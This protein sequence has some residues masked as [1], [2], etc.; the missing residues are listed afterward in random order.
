MRPGAAPAE[1]PG[2]RRGR[3]RFRLERARLKLAQ[4]PLDPGVL[5]PMFENLLVDVGGLLPVPLL[6]VELGQLLILAD[7]PVLV[8]LA[9]ELF[10]QE[11]PDVDG[12]WIFLNETVQ[13]L[14]D[15][16][17]VPAPR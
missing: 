9:E 1:L 4:A 13:D 5:G 12:G 16:R 14:V 7:R 10:D 8:S 15:L 17:V 3:G 6:D 11:V 2:G